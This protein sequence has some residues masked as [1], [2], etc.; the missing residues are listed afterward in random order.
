MEGKPLEYHY[1]RGLVEDIEEQLGPV[2][3]GDPVPDWFFIIGRQITRFTGSQDIVL[4][5]EAYDSMH[6]ELLRRFGI[7]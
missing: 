2:L 3:T 6:N 7:G 5:K 1:Q 4:S